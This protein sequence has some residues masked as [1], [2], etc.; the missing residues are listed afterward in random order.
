MK[1]EKFEEILLQMSKPEV[2]QLKHQGILSNTITKA[3]DN[4]V[5]SSWWL[6]I[7]L[8]ILATL[9]MK[10]FFTP[11]TTL[12][13]N[14][15]DLTTKEKYFS[16]LFFAVLP[17]VLIVLNFISIRNIYFLSGSP[18]T[19]AFVRIVWLNALIIIVSIII[20]IIYLL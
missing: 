11:S 1:M 6:S 18:K 10:K 14:L 16:V 20:L 17:I 7:P 12:M 13:S 2:S 4:S 9:L 15:H 5:L 19:A 8:Y 3:K